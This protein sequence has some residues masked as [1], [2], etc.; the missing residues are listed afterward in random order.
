VEVRRM[1]QIIRPIKVTFESFKSY[2]KA[3]EKCNLSVNGW[4]YSALEAV[5]GG[6]V[7]E[8]FS[9]VKKKSCKR[10]ELGKRSM[11]QSLVFHASDFAKF[12]KCA[13]EANMKVGEWMRVILDHYAGVSNIQKH[14]RE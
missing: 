11:S 12:E 10:S 7:Y 1:D 6:D 13:L 5:T 4:A 14:V 8:G 9:V 2:K 3:A